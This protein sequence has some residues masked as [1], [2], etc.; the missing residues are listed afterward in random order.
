MDTAYRSFFWIDTKK[1]GIELADIAL[2]KMGTFTVELRR[3]SARQLMTTCYKANTY[4]TP[5]VGIRVLKS[6]GVKSVL[7]DL[8]PA[9]R[10]IVKQVPECFRVLRSSRKTTTQPYNRYWH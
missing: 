2:K 5:Y 9:A 3:V 7:G 8:A 4:C 1:L 10:A 6:F